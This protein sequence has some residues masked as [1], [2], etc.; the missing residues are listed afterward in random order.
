MEPNPAQKLRTDAVRYDTNDFSAVLRRVHVDPVRPLPN[1]SLTN[2][3]VAHATSAT[4][5]LEGPWPPRPST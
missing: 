1:G 5:A 2:R 4:S 3:V